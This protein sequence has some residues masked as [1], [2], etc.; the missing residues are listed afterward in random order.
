MRNVR[1][2]PLRPARE[3][4]RSL[5]H[6]PDARS[7]SKLSSMLQRVLLDLLDGGRPMPRAGVLMMRS[8]LM[9]SCGLTRL[10]IREISLTSAR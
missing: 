6:A 1:P 10:Q 3:T 9:E 2:E 5:E 4:C 8:R 7:T